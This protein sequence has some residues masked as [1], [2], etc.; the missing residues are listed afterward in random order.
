MA[1]FSGTTAVTANLSLEMEAVW[2]VVLSLSFSIW[3]SHL[4]GRIHR[5]L[6]P[7]FRSPVDMS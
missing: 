1:G 2:H 5:P 6:L 4:P 3:F 7:G